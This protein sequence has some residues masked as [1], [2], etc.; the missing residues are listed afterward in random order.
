[1]RRIFYLAMVVVF[2]GLV[3]VALLGAVAEMPR[4]GSPDNPPHNEVYQ[5]Y[6]EDGLAD[7]G[8]Y[9]LVANIILDYRAYDTLM[10]TTVL[11]TVV[12]III[13][14]WGVEGREKK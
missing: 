7:C 11:F 3:G 8:G 12:V 5:R 6:V 2:V 14:M 1:M 4:Y 13:M 9:N 10:E